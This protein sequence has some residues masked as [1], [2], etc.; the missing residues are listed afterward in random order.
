M[1]DRRQQGRAKPIAAG[2]GSPLQLALARRIWRAAIGRG[3]FLDFAQAIRKRT[4]VQPRSPIFPPG[5]RGGAAGDRRRSGGG[6][7]RARG[8]ARGGQ[9]R[10]RPAAP[11]GRRCLCPSAPFALSCRERRRGRAADAL[12]PHGAPSAQCKILPHGESSWLPA[13]SL[14]PQARTEP[15]QDCER[16]RRSDPTIVHFARFCYAIIEVCKARGFSAA[17]GGAA[18]SMRF[19]RSRKIFRAFLAHVAS[20]TAR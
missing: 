1:E 12:R 10:G 5:V 2:S 6:R 20:E 4:P 11:G 9:L 19:M 8:L 13:E 17:V 18:T 3:A 15:L 14:K 7:D 16:A